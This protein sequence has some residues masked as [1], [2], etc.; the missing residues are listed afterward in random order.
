VV[1]DV[2]WAEV[3]AFSPLAAGLSRILSG[4]RIKA[5]QRSVEGIGRQFGPC[6]QLLPGWLATLA[7]LIA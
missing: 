3:E 5:P 7:M 4:C 2:L 1:A 6:R